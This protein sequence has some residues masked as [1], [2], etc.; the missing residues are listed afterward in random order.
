MKRSNFRVSV[1]PDF[2]TRNLPSGVLAP[3][4]QMLFLV[5]FLRIGGTLA[6]HAKRGDNVILLS[7]TYGIHVHTER[8]RDKSVEEMKDIVREKSTEP[9]L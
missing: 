7:V 8:L 2:G 9:R 3:I 1:S 5:L 6:K 4:H